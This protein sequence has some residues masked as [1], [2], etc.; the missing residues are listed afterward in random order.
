MREAEAKGARLLEQARH[1]RPSSRTPPAPRSSRRSSGRARRPASSSPAP[2]PGA[3]QLLTAAG[4]GPDALAEVSN[5]IMAA[6]Q[7]STDVSRARGGGGL[8]PAPPAEPEQPRISAVPEEEEAEP[9]AEPT[10]DEGAD[11]GGEMPPVSAPPVSGPPAP[12]S[13]EQ[14]EDA[15]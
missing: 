1:R 8:P 10:S 13:S 6:A 12:A 7:A 11:E 2:R 4:L 15:S 5:A 3:E 9:V 14:G